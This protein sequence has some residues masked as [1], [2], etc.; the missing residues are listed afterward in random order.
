VKISSANPSIGSA[1][2]SGRPRPV[3]GA[4]T[5]PA[6]G[7]D[8]QVAL[9]SLSSRMQEIATN[10]SASPMVDAKRVSEIKQ[11]ISEGR[12]QIDPERIADGLLNSVRQMLAK[13]S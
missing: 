12:F 11:A 10:T 3:S 1:P 8:A 13:N 7:G 5:R 4:A 2:E 6:A 9:S